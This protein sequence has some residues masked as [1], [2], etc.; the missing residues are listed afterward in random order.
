[1]RGDGGGGGGFPAPAR[2]LPLRRQRRTLWQTFCVCHPPASTP[3]R[4][5]AAR[6]HGLTCPR[7]AGSVTVRVSS[8]IRQELGGPSTPALGISI[9]TSGFRVGG[10]LSRL[11]CSRLHHFGSPPRSLDTSQ[12]RGPRPPRLGDTAALGAASTLLKSHETLQSADLH[13]DP[14]ERQ[15]LS[16]RGEPGSPPGALHA[17]TSRP[18]AAYLARALTLDRKSV[19]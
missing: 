7:V 11:P 4:G 8:L 15:R 18:G 10:R 17:Q 14:R 1:M 2:T 5:S 16:V 9:T 12:L 19:V 3:A 13:A 6:V